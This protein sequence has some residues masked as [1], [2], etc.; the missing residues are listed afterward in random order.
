M[1]PGQV[2]KLVRFYELVLDE[3]QRQ[4]LTRLT[5]PEQFWDGMIVDALELV[6][7]DFFKG[8]ALDL[9]TGCGVPGIIC[10][11]LREDSWVLVDSERRKTDFVAYAAQELGLTPRVAVK[12]GRIELLLRSQ[13]PVQ[14]IVSKAVGP[15]ERL[16][17]WIRHCSTWNNLVL[18]KGPAWDE[19][20]AQFQRKPFGREL[21]LEAAHEYTSGEYRRRLVRLARV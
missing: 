18:L 4:N 14:S 1:L 9:G 17:G 2:D 13:G 8:P 15:V 5:T 21:K 6:K 7:A 10:A 11:I 12:W 16:Y 3:N 20:W 19:E